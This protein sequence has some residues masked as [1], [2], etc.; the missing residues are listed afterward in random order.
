MPPPKK[1]DAAKKAP[2]KAEEDL[3]DLSSLPH[4][5]VFTFTTLFN[6]YLQ[7][8]RDIVKEGI[9]TLLSEESLASKEKLKHVK[10]ITRQSIIDDLQG[11]LY[12]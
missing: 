3:S 5:K 11:K 1:A 7:K 8:S 4:I 9:E 2:A 10:T 12:I 6:F